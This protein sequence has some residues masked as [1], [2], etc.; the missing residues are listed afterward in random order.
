MRRKSNKI[1]IFAFGG[2]RA[3][4]KTTQMQ[5]KNNFVMDASKVFSSSKTFSTII[6]QLNFATNFGHF[7]DAW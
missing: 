3:R 1:F 4:V 5:V 2:Y 6:K 7:E